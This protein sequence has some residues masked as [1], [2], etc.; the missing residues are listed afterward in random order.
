[1]LEFGIA[2]LG[3]GEWNETDIFFRGNGEII[4]ATK[5]DEKLL[6]EQRKT[7]ALEAAMEEVRK[8]DDD[9]VIAKLAVR[10]EEIP[11]A[12]EAA[13]PKETRTEETLPKTG[14]EWFGLEDDGQ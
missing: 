9:A 2:G 6:E 11:S 7:E 10:A 8:R 13:P 1:L 12:S 5:M 3:N 4:G 14:A